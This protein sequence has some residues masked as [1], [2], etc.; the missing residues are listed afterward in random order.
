MGRRTR[1]GLVLGALAGL[2]G[3]A[4]LGLWWILHV[5]M[6]DTG[7]DP[8][9]YSGLEVEEALEPGESVGGIRLR[10]SD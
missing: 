2:A 10:D 8:R 3:L 4:A 1:N 6:A 9:G 7:A 5:A